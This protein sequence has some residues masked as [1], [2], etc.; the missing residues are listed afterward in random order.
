[1]KYLAI[2]QQARKVKV[3][4]TTIRY[5]GRRGLISPPQ[6]KKLGIGRIESLCVQEQEES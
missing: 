3:S 2:G 5:Y 6:R 4:I 1:M